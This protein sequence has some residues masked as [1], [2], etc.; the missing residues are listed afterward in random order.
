[1]RVGTPPS[2]WHWGLFDSDSD[3]RFAEKV[4]IEPELQHYDKL[5]VVR[6]RDSN[7]QIA[8][9]VREFDIRTQLHGP[10][11]ESATRFPHAIPSITAKLLTRAFMPVARIDEVTP[12]NEAF[13]KS[14]GIE[15][16]IRTSIN[17]DLEAEVVPTRDSPVYIRKSERFQPVVLRT[18]RSGKITKL[19]AIPFTFIVANSVDKND[20]KGK[21]HST[22][23]APLAGRKSKRAEKLALVIRPPAVSYTH[24]TLP[25]NR[26]V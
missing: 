1:M 23:R 13:L 16:C 11:I 25:T 24:L 3:T 8:I 21:L 14:R 15:A 6:I 22:K 19:D 7:D 12:G 20:I 5:M 4:L 18:D 26:E 9:D 17:E 2:Q 10:R